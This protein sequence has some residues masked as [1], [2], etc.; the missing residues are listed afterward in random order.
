VNLRQRTLVDPGVGFGKRTPQNLEL[1]ARAG[2]QGALLGRPVIVG[3]SRKRY[4]G[5][6]FQHLG[7]RDVGARDDA[8]VGAC[9]AAVAAGADA[10]RVHDV[11]RVHDALVAFNAVRGVS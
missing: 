3:P 4:L 8:T 5:E 9:L 7:G 6:L 2:E 10:L 11:R 1:L